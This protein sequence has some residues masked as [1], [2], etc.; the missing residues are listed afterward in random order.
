[1]SRVDAAGP[2]PWWESPAARAKDTGRPWWESPQ[3]AA[4]RSEQAR[5]PQGS[6]LQ[7]IDV[8]YLLKERNHARP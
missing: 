7:K 2:V 6:D 3:A 8:G 4:H 1:M 5:R